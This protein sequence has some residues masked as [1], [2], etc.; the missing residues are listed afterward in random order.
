MST[1]VLSKTEHDLGRIVILALEAHPG[2]TRDDAAAIVGLAL[3]TAAN[4]A[5]SRAL[6]LLE[7]L[8]EAAPQSGPGVLERDVDHDALCVELHAA[9]TLLIESGRLL[10]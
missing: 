5:R 10:P 7:R 3:R 1:P 2:Q 9:Y 8:L 6:D 4:A